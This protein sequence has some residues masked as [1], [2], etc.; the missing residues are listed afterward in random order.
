MTDADPGALIVPATVSPRTA[1]LALIA[2]R[3]VVRQAQPR[4]NGQPLPGDLVTAVLELRQVA[5][6]RGELDH[7]HLVVS[8]SE[9]IDTRE[10]ARR[11]GVSVRTVQER[12]AA[13]RLPATRVGRRSW[14]VHWKD[15]D[16][17]T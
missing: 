13:G 15:T 10:A 16:D 2:L 7:A 12:C 8:A 11:L 14:L 4:R 3:E 1:E 9:Q 6:T 5:A 17:I